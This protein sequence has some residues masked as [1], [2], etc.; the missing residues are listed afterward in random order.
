MLIIWIIRRPSESSSTSSSNLDF[1]LRCS[2]ILSADLVFCRSSKSSGSSSD[3]SDKCSGKF[4]FSLILDLDAD[5]C[6]S[7]LIFRTKPSW[8]HR[9][10]I[11]HHQMVWCHRSDL[12]KYV[13]MEPIWINLSRSTFKRRK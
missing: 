3:W 2:D 11:T 12:S 4:F 1:L 6:Q 9:F 7:K 10:Y 5:H 8:Y 13:A